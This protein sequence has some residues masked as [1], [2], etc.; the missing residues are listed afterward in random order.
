MRPLSF[1]AAHGPKLSLAMTV[2]TTFVHASR[3]LERFLLDAR[4]E[5]GH[6][7]THQTWQS[8]LAVL[9]TFRARLTP[10]EGLAFADALPPLLAAML[11]QDWELGQPPR[12]FADRAVLAREAMAFRGDHSILP[13]SGIADV[14]RAL[15]R[16]VDP[17]AFERA[18]AKLPPG[19]R[20]F[21]AI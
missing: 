14:A 21:W 15:R 18:L 3:D 19:A 16:H 5:L 13:E 4:D 11:L 7:T 8:V 6:A 10:A 1:T 2:P 20:E 17:Q 9:V 12:P